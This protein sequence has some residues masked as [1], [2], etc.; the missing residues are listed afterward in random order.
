M[1]D[2]SLQPGDWVRTDSGT[3]GQIVLV[4]RLTAFVDIQRDKT[5]YIATFLVSKLT[6]IDEPQHDDA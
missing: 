2:E 5:S 3:V 4:D 1:S 6:K